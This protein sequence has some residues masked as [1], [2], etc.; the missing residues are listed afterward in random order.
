MSIY[1]KLYIKSVMG[2][3]AQFGRF[4]IK[5]FVFSYPGSCSVRQQKHRWNDKDCMAVADQITYQ[6]YNDEQHYF[7]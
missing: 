6:A 7:E 1:L 4:H 5:F 2:E 3:N